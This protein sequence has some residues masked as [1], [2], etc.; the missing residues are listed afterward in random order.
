MRGAIPGPRDAST[1]DELN[2]ITLEAEVAGSHRPSVFDEDNPPWLILIATLI[3]GSDDHLI[4]AAC[5]AC[6]LTQH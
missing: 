1:R 4:R 3:Y 6:A 5:I 2:P